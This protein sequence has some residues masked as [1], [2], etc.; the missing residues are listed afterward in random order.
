MLYSRNNEKEAWR[1]RKEVSQYKL[2]MGDT[3][4]QSNPVSISPNNDRFWK[5]KIQAETQFTENQLP[6]IRAGWMPKKLYFLAQGNGPFTL[7]F[8]NYN[9]K[10][11]QRN[12]LAD[13]ID[14]IKRSG[15]SIDRVSIGEII[16][17]NKS[18]KVEEKTPWKLILLWLVLIL[19]TALMGFMAYRLFQQMGRDEAESEDKNS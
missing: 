19:G 5:L 12:S 14:S 10:P 17:S 6:E 15:A 7:A 18:F 11:D 13:L 2:N 1:Y 16:N 4:L 9:I 8:G 3:I